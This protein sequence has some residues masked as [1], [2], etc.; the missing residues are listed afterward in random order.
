[1]NVLTM[2]RNIAA[3]VID[4][5]AAGVPS[6]SADS[7]LANVL[8]IVWFAMGFAAVLVIIIS[9]YQYMTSNGDPGKASKARST[10]LY[11]VIGLVVAVSAFAITN[12]VIGRF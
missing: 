2:L 8:N 9:G 5:G 12:W 4:A 6:Q 11:A 10:I 7:L 1:M 3:P